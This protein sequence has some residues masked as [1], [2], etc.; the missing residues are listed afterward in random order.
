MTPASQH[1]AA[2]SIEGAAV[3]ELYLLKGEDLSVCVILTVCPAPER[4]E[5]RPGPSLG[6]G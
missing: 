6:N 2:H 4:Q 5:Q 1:L 3:A